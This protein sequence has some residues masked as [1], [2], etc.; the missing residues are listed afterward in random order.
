MAQGTQGTQV[1]NNIIQDNIYGIGLANTGPSQVRICQN[2]LQ[3]N[4]NPGSA[5]GSGIYTDQFVCVC[6]W[7]R[8][9]KP[10]LYELPHHREHVQGARR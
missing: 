4:N 10:P 9:R 8:Q 6:L 5:S 7:K 2:L 3:N 1:Y